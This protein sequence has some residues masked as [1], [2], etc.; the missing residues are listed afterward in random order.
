MIEE[1]TDKEQ[2]RDHD[3]H[4]ADLDSYTFQSCTERQGL[5]Q[6]FRALCPRQPIEDLE[7]YI[8]GG[9]YGFSS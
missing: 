4:H 1:Y 5:R 6:S 9:D 3:G 2:D 7:R 8:T